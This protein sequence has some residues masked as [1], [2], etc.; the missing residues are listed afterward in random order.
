MSTHPIFPDNP[1]RPEPADSAA[2]ELIRQKVSRAYGQEPSASE[3]L[4]KAKHDRAPSKH[5]LFMKQLAEAGKNLAEVQTEWH[6]YYT[7]LPDDEKREVWDEF[8]AA[9]EYTPYQKLFQKQQP[10]QSRAQI[11]PRVINAAQT[12]Y[13][14]DQNATALNGVMV[15]DLSTPRTVLPPKTK[16]KKRKSGAAKKTGELIRKTKVGRRVA[17]SRTAEKTRHIK[18]KIQQKVSAGG[19]LEARHHIQSLLFGLGVGAIMLLFLLFGFFNEYIITPF[20]QPSSKVS[21]MPIIVSNISADQAANPTVIVP[22]INIQIPIDFNLTTTD[23]STIQSSLENGIVHYSST[24]KPGQNGNGAYFG[25]SS[26]NLL[27]SGKYKFAF[28]RLR[29]LTTGDIFYV[30]YQGKVYGYQVFAKEIVPPSQV[31]VLGDTKGEQAT[32]VLITC[33]PPGFSTNR[34]VVWG[35]QISPNVASNTTPGTLPAVPEPVQI[36]SNGPTLWTRM[37]RSIEFWR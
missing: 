6:H 20:I 15:G 26:Q 29:E 23:E 28:V 9:N 11:E 7:Q 4:V 12:P 24:V 13:V 16:R 14:P 32:A 19:R 21:S 37:W 33:D 8:Y 3:E 25:H 30:T 34:L 36:T 22:K 1:L 35:K 17:D 5:Q 18:Q 2:V 31:S 27:N 10:V